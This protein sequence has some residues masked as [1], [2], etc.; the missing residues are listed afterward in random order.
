MDF[1]AATNEQL[2]RTML[3]SVLESL[4]SLCTFDFEAGQPSGRMT[5]RTCIGALTRAMLPSFWKSR[6]TWS[7]F[8]PSGITEE[9]ASSRKWGLLDEAPLHVS[10][11][12][13]VAAITTES[14]SLA[15]LNPYT[16]KDRA[17]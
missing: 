4:L 2:R 6:S 12:L 9:A 1:T 14:V 13:A 17:R 15:W 3:V 8:L 16:R 10:E 11:L 7:Q 5:Q